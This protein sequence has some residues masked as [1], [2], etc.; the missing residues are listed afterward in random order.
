MLKLIVLT[1]LVL[2][3]VAPV[4]S[5]EE[6]CEKVMLDLEQK[7]LEVKSYSESVQKLIAAGDTSTATLLNKKIE[8]SLNWILFLEERLGKCSSRTV[9]GGA[10]SS[11]SSVKSDEL[12]CQ[13]KECKDLRKNMLQLLRKKH[14]LIR[15][16]N[17]VFSQLTIEDQA[18][19]RVTEQEIKEIQE[20]LK[21]NCSQDTTP[22]FM[23]PKQQK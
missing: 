13:G 11:T 3:L 6:S 1:S 2:M 15:R 9:K 17:S 14:S 10:N 23:R 21:K 8:D 4:Y 5:Q 12:K 7:R 22:R 18:V 19:L 20:C 16:V